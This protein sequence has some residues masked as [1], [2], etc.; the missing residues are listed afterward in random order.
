MEI[1]NI[2]EIKDLMQCGRYT[3]TRVVKQSGLAIN[4]GKSQKI[5]VEK[6]AFIKYLQQ[7]GW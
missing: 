6:E 7:T 3:A 2:N 4:K 1:L 5:L